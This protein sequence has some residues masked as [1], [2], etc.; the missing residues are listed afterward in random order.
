M[1]LAGLLARAALRRPDADAVVDGARR[2]TYGELERL[3]ASL[4]GG[5]TRLGVHKGDRVLIALRNRAEHVLAYWALQRIGGVP[6]PVNFRLAAGEMA[7][8]LDDSGARVVL[9][10][11]ATGPAVLPAARGRDLILI[12]A[13]PDPPVEAVAFESLLAEGPGPDGE[14][15][16]EDLSLILYTSGT[17][18]RPKGVPRTHQNHYAGALAHVIQ[19]GYEWGERT[20]GVMPLYHTMGIHSLTSMVAVNG[21]FVCQPD[22]SAAGALGRIAAERLTAL[23]LIPTLFYD[24]VHAP[25]LAPTDVSSVKKLA[26]AGAPMLAPLTEACLKAFGPR[27]FV[28]HYGSTEIYTFSV[29]PD[30]H[31]KPGCA[32]RPGIHSTLRVVVASTERR[33]GPDEV[34]PPG[35][36]GEI[37]ARLDSDEAFAGYWNRPDADARALRDGWYFTGDMGYVDVE[38]ELYVAG[39][40]DDMI[41]SGGENIHPVEVEEVLARHP[42]VRDVAVVGEPDE[43]WGER[44]VAFVV[45]AARDLTAETLD[46]YCRESPDLASFKRPRR[47]V[48]VEDIPKTASGKILRRLLREDGSAQPQGGGGAAGDARPRR[49]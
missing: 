33:V 39:R 16:E 14:A 29:R 20:L 12:S 49:A 27:V 10:E 44:V 31:L 5:F 6:T 26:Y 34:V 28:N 38:G 24:L 25:G 9:F 32:G 18:G 3:S 35:Q 4:A 47:I 46:G 40:V 2:L 17:T 43:R 7:Y 19:C 1:T 23:Y 36:K 37:I 48:F 41:I 22:W 11:G 21:C 8:L 42:G 45:P 13:D 30:V 15:G